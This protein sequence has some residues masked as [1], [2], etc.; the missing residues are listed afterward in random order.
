MKNNNLAAEQS[1]IEMKETSYRD[2]G[3]REMNPALVV[4]LMGKKQISVQQ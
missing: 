4:D 3:L 2:E 1:E